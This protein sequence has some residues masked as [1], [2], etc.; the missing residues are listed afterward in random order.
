MPVIRHTSPTFYSI[1][2]REVM[3][4]YASH[5]LSVPR[6]NVLLGSRALRI[7]APLTQI[8][9]SLY[10]ISNTN[11]ANLLFKRQKDTDINPVSE[12]GQK[13]NSKVPLI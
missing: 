4:S 5:L 12:A 9:N 3:R 11:T 8:W 7:N 1:K 13:G 2:A 10:P 6:H